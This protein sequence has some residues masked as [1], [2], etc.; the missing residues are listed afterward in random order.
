M[1]FNRPGETLSRQQQ[2]QQLNVFHM[3]LRIMLLKVTKGHRLFEKSLKGFERFR[4]PVRMIQTP[5]RI[6]KMEVMTGINASA[7]G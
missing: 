7:D 4:K 1:N 5:L 2:N 3:Q 6:V